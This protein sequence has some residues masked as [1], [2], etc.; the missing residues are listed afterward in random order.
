LANPRHELGERAEAATAHWL[1]TSGWQVLDQ[2]WRDSSG[3]LDLVCRDPAG[4]LVAV[5]VKLRRTGRA[6]TAL[7]AVDRGRLLRLRRALAAYALA[8]ARSWPAL[9]VD[10]VTVAPAGDSWLLRRYPGI[11]AW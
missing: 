9:R 6:G 4:A 8:S 10:L 2:R 3:E 11:D 7:E 5:E 1:V